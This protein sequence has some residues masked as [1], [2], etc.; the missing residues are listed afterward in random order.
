MSGRRRGAVPSIV[1]AA[2]L[3]LETA[4]EP[5]VFTGGRRVTWQLFDPASLSGPV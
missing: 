3:G 5:L 2:V 4:Q 1:L